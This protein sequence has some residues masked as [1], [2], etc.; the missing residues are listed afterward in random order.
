MTASRAGT[1]RRAAFET[2]SCGPGAVDLVPR[3][4]GSLRNEARVVARGISARGGFRLC[5]TSVS[6][7]DRSGRS[8]A[9]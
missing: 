7:D 3:G 1:I 9:W 4:D 6:D 5:S 8:A 2:A